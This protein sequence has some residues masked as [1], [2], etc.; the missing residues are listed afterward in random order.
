ME[1]SDTARSVLINKLLIVSENLRCAYLVLYVC[2]C[3]N[4]AALVLY[5]KLYC[6]VYIG[7]WQSF[8]L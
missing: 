1:I 5:N 4:F 7:W 2:K 8:C 6:L 3:Y